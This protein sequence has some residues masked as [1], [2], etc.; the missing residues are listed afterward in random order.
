MKRLIIICEGQTE[1][2]FC[3]DILYPYFFAQNI[4]I[5][6]PLIKKTHGGIVKWAEL[7]RQVE[8]HLKQE[9]DIFVTTFIDFYALPSDYLDFDKLSRTK[10][11]KLSNIEDGMKKDIDTSINHRFIPYIQ[12]HEFECFLFY[13]LD[14]LKNNFT[15]QEAN[16]SELEKVIDTYPNLEDINNN[17][18]TAPSKRLLEHIKGYN[19]IVY[20]AC[21]ASDIG[22]ANIRKKCPR[23]SNW[24]TEL[25][26]IK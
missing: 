19:K 4:I 8:R 13:S 15:P 24:I 18:L 20:G 7:R 25:E 26:K 16:F 3:Q 5:S 9:K 22:L 23:F 14:I 1:Q 11:E 10:L 21:L 12:L 6:Y 2:E 17:P